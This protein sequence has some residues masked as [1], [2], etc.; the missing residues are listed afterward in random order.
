MTHVPRKHQQGFTYLGL[1]ILL[2]IIMIVATAS[3]QLGKIEQ[4]RLAEQELLHIGREFQLALLSYANSTPVGQNRRP[5]TL[6]ELV[7]DPRFPNTQRHLRKIYLD[8]I[9]GKAE[10]GIV[11]SSDQQRII[12]VFSLS[13]K[14]PIKIKNFDSYFLG[15]DEKKSYRDWV[16]VGVK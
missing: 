13:D 9:T 8:P 2:V 14:K 3:I 5:K 1:M 7:K 16:F 4:Q 10:W 15:F 6:Q 12:G 11:L